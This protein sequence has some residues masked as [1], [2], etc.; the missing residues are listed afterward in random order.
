MRSQSEFCAG[1]EKV[2]RARNRRVKVCEE[3]GPKG[4]TKEI[5][6]SLKRCIAF[7]DKQSISKVDKYGEERVVGEVCLLGKMIQFEGTGGPGRRNDKGYDFGSWEARIRIQ[8][9]LYKAKNV[10]K[11]VYV[12]QRQ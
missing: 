5:L 6:D 12:R 9:L 2:V 3:K 1:A 7:N 11:F 8:E 10:C 4:F